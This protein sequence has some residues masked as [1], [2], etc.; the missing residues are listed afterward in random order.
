MKPGDAPLVPPGVVA[1]RV[2]PWRGGRASEETDWIAEE[3]PVALVFNGISHAVM[4]A[5]PA[6]LDDFALGFAITEGLLET[7]A[8]LYGIE[9]VDGTE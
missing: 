4:L 2:R 3:R 7:P 6:D 9:R 8:E 1:A 5:S